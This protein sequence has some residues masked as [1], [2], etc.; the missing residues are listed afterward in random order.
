MTQ[1][2]GKRS[3][4]F[5]LHSQEL[6]RIGL[7]A[8]LES[9]TEFSVVGEAR[10]REEALPLIMELKPDIAVLDLR[11]QIGQASPTANELLAGLADTRVLF[12]AER[13]DDSILLS[14]I[15]TGGHG[16]VLQEAGIATFLHALRTVNQGQPYLDPGMTHYAFAYLRKLANRKPQQGECDLLSPQ[17]QRLLPLIAQGKTNKEI[18]RELG[19]SDK[20][21]KN[22]LANVY[23]KLRVARRSQA[24]AFYMTRF[25]N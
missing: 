8:L 1:V 11:V 14:A 18:A 9:T 24:A 10:S 25:R 21:V 7:R 23:A 19:L 4:V 5:I 16:Y 6:V 22:Y 13:L 20:T 17:E 2:P 3:R 15:A 12:L